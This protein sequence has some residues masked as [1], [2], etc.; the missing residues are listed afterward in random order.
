ADEDDLNQTA[1]GPLSAEFCDWRE[2][3]VYF[4]KNLAEFYIADHENNT[5]EQML[6]YCVENSLANYPNAA[7]LNYWPLTGR[8][9]VKDV[10]HAVSLKPLA[11]AWACDVASGAWPDESSSL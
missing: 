11:T 6:D 10:Q 3:V 8:C 9:V 7:Q 1:T 4:G 5:R 2:G